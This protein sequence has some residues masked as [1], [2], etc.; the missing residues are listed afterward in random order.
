MANATRYQ[1]LTL[2]F[3]VACAAI[4]SAPAVRAA[5]SS[6]SELRLGILSI[7]PPSRI[8]KSWQPF[9][10]YLAVQ[11]AQPVSLVVPRGFKT[12]KDA[13][14]KGEVDFFY[15]NSYVFYRLKQEGKA[16]GILQMKNVR[17]EVTSRSEIFVRQDSGIVTID[18]LKGQGIAYVSPM[19]AGGYLAPRAYLMSQG[20]DSGVELK[21]H[22]TKN[23]SSSIHAVLLNDSSAG[24][25]CGINFDLM[26]KKM[27]MGELKIL[28][29]S[30]PYP[31][32]IIAARPSLDT[33]TI[34][35]F[36][37][38][39]IHMKNHPAGQQVL[40][41]MQTMRIREFIP[42]DPAIEQLTENLLR[43]AKLTH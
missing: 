25:M 35:K 26:N 10:E 9:A 24:T 8:Y 34:E 3:A 15:I 18:Q 4:G 41:D 20:I 19:G 30:A 40:K 27:D 6:A 21:E 39:V 1:L 7:A 13:A 37:Q 32:N 2:L 22:F 42:Y 29:V 11:M 36:T 31:E 5:D 28:A 43:Q 38:A 33:K 23:L 14:E 12:M 16:I 17:D